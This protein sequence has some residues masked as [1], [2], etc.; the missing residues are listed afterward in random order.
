MKQRVIRKAVF[1]IVF[2]ILLI[3]VIISSIWFS[4]Y[5]AYNC[6]NVTTSISYTY[7]H[8]NEKTLFEIGT[9]KQNSFIVWNIELEQ[10]KLDMRILDEQGL[11]VQMA[12][13]PFHDGMY[14]AF[15]KYEDKYFFELNGK[16]AR[17]NSHVFIRDIDDFS[18]LRLFQ[19]QTLM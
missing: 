18:F 5:L 2:V 12:E 6:S 17:F 16:Q 11:P 4:L 3:L 14:L 1:F 8:L 7:T 13:S 19:K 9:I 15:I 10:G